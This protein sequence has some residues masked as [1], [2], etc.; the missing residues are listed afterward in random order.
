M[1]TLFYLTLLV[2]LIAAAGPAQAQTDDALP[3]GPIR[4]P[5]V[6]QLPEKKEVI[7]PPTNTQTRQTTTE[8]KPITPNPRQRKQPAGG[9]SAN[10]TPKPPP[11]P[12]PNFRITG[13]I[14]N[15]SRP[16]AI[17]NGQVLDIGDEIQGFRI[18]SINPNGI[19]VSI[20]GVTLTVEP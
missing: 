17:I 13:L 15:S 6:P 5:F 20:R 3:D 4:N 10:S 11:I 19:D 9:Q 12:K 14:W 7:E 16:Q 1:R 2:G 8:T 18:E